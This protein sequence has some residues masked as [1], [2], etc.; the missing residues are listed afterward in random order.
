MHKRHNPDTVV[1]AF[2]K[3]YSQAL[4]VDPNK[5][6]LFTAGQ[7]GAAPDGSTPES[8]EDQVAQTWA[9]IMALLKEAD[10]GADD[11]VKIVGYIVGVENFSAYVAGR[12]K[13]IGGVR[14][15]STA[16]V[17]PA[18]ALPELLVEIEVIAAK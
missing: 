9:N 17:V 14:P 10:M 6:W 2:G 5:R 8:F 12:K 4:E 16:I 7:I 11:I 15:A 3:G 18:L 13:V 1:E